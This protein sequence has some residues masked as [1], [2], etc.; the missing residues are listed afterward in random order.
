LDRFSIA[1][2]VVKKTFLDACAR[3]V[4]HDEHVTLEEA[5]LVRA[6]AYALEVPLPPFLETW[7]D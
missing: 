7:R 2:P 6:V 4:L 5:E 1:T 3:C